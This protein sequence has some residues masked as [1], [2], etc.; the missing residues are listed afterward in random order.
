[1]NSRFDNHKHYNDRRPF[2]RKGRH[3]YKHRPD[4]TKYGIIHRVRTQTGVRSQIVLVYN[5]QLYEPISVLNNATQRF[6][7]QI[8]IQNSGP[9]P[10]DKSRS[11]FSL[12]VNNERISHGS[13]LQESTAKKHLYELAI[14]N[15][16]KTCFS[17]LRKTLPRDSPAVT[18]DSSTSD[19]NV[20][21]QTAVGGIGAK[22]MLKM[23]W[24]GGGLGAQAQGITDIVQPTQQ[25][26]RKGFGT[27]IT[28]P[29]DKIREILQGY[30]ESDN[31]NGISFSP[32]FTKEERSVI[33]SVAQKMNLKS[34]SYGTGADRRLVI[35][36]KLDP[37]QLVHKLLE[38]GGENEQYQLVMPTEFVNK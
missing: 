31:I 12:N 11:C 1:M 10:N 15:L 19:T 6:K 32:D 3:P 21:P 27:H 7:G 18:L 20:Q 8:Q 38:V 14:E 30:V 23:G 22:M 4:T 16:R 13:Y 17:I 9:D 36:K 28:I 37:W 33:H 25:I 34:T 5:P 29:I 24:A 2:K 26:E 35:Q